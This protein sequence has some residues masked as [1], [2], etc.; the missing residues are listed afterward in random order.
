MGIPARP[1]V[2]M[3]WMGNLGQMKKH[4][5]RVREV[6]HAPCRYYRDVDLDAAIAGVGLD[7][8]FWDKH[9]ICPDCGRETIFM[10]S[11]GPGTVFRPMLTQ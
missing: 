1:P 2:R 6:C 4:G 9:W 7:F 3:E 10:C 5:T 8:D 11:A